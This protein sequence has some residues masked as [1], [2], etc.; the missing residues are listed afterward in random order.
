MLADFVNCADVWMVQRRGRPC[1]TPEALESLLIAGD[2]I[3][4]EFQRD[5]A[6]EL[7]VFSLEDHTHPTAAKLMQ[8]VVMGDGLSLWIGLGHLRNI[9]AERASRVR[10]RAEARAT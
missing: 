6:A 9:L 8:D 3:G 4:E 5:K 10:C 1:L 7:R 2:I